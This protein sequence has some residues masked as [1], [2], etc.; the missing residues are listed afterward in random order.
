MVALSDD[1]IALVICAD[2]QAGNDAAGQALSCCGRRGG[3]RGELVALEEGL[4]DALAGCAG[5]LG[6]ELGGEDVVFGDGA[7]ELFRAV[8]GGCHCPA[9]L[10][11]LA[12]AVRDGEGVDVVVLA[13]GP[14]AVDTL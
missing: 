12:G 11:K 1:K 14:Q 6:V 5:L 4:E 2:V 9:V 10:L 7:D 3:Q 8:F 13:L